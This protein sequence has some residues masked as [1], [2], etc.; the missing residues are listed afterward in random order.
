MN[1]FI[2]VLANK[3]C[4]HVSFLSQPL[5]T[6]RCGAAESFKAKVTKVKVS[7]PRR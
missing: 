3:G 6:M 1:I 2:Y 4:K 5:G 7:K